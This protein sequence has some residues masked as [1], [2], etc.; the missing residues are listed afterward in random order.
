MSKKKKVD[1]NESP[2][3]KTLR[4]IIEQTSEKCDQIQKNGRE[5]LSGIQW[6][7]DL[8]KTT[9]PLIQYLGPADTEKLI[10]NWTF[11]L[12]SVTQVNNNLLK[13]R[14]TFDYSSGSP[15]GAF[16]TTSVAHTF[17]YSDDPIKV[18]A[19]KQFLKVVNLPERRRSV[20]NLF[21]ELSLDQPLNG[22]I[23]PIAQFEIAFEAYDH[24]VTDTDPAATSL[25]PMRECIRTLLGVLLK[26]RPTQESAKPE[27]EKIISIG[28][29]LCKGGNSESVII[30][31]ADQWDR[32][33]NLDLS[34]AK[35]VPISRDEWTDRITRATLFLESFLSGLD[36]QKFRK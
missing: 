21:H 33:D 11:N 23:S 8:G 9:L 28:K 18:K 15:S 2:G 7:N 16:N 26:L 22:E 13:V 5:L 17:I 4:Q 30:E 29:Q 6:T 24:P 12:G 32:L 36:R 1:F 20:I 27:R 10:D 35:N 25:V 34:P 3:Q 31:W 19:Y 14:Q